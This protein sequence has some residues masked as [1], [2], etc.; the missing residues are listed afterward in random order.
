MV[1]RL[2]ETQLNNNLVRQS[3]VSAKC[4]LVVLHQLS[5][6]YPGSSRIFHLI[7]GVLVHL[8]DPKL[9]SFHAVTEK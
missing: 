1:V 6:V 9:S 5:K 7:S 8:A 2:A 4:T 3:S